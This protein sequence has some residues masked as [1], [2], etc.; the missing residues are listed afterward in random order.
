MSH[1]R[2]DMKWIALVAL[3]VQNSGL[4]VVMRLS[5]LYSEP[6]SRYLASTAVLNAEIMKFCIST[7]C[8][9]LF[10]ANM[11]WSTFQSILKQELLHNQV[12]HF[13]A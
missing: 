8:C 7:V 10:D 2:F 3:V 6:G 4:A 5:I 1:P 11:S 12:C 13:Y 9:F